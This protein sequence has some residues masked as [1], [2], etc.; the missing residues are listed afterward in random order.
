MLETVSQVERDCEINEKG[1][2]KIRSELE[3]HQV[4]LRREVKQIRERDARNLV[5]QIDEILEK[6]EKEMEDAVRIRVATDTIEKVDAV[7]G[8][9]KMD[10]QLAAIKEED[11]D[12]SMKGVYA[13]PPLY[14][15][16]EVRGLKRRRAN[17]SST[18]SPIRLPTSA[19][20]SVS[21]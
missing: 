3:K 12:E 16:P 7:Q 6:M 18:P 13:P 5:E 1:L 9:L 19:P 21:A 14:D 4:D 8:L 15:S 11:R 17:G 10:G 2:T 20:I